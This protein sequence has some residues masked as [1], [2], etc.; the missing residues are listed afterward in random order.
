MERNN[1][2]KKSLAFAVILLFIGLAFAP[3]INA[4]VS[5]ASQEDELVKITTEVCGLNGGKQT[6][7]LTQDEMEEVKALFDSIREKLDATESREEGEDIFKEAVLELD[8]YGLLGDLSIKQAQRLVTGGYQNIR[9]MKILRRMIDG[10]Q[11]IN[12]SSL[13]CLTA[14][15]ATN[16]F[17][18]GPLVFLSLIGILFPVFSNLWVFIFTYFPLAPFGLMV[19]GDYSIGQHAVFYP[20]E[21][22]IRTIGLT[23]FKK[24]DGKF[25]GQLLRIDILLGGLFLGGIG[26]TGLRINYGFL[27]TF[28]LGSTLILK[29]GPK[30]L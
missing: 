15:H 5:K 30:H 29:I 14:G 21:G 10:N 24:W 19:F 22:W 25:Y 20:A 18:I 28:F 3:S 11:N 9:I 7:K 27:N 13:L 17:I 16:S 8:K 12:N 23:G 4:N 26:F 6:I 1:L 2:I